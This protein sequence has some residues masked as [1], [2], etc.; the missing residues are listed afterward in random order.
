MALLIAS[1]TSAADTLAAAGRLLAEIHVFVEGV[2]HGCGYQLHFLLRQ[3]IPVPGFD[4][5][6]A[7]DEQRRAGDDYG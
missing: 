2:I 1:A 3:Q 4:V 6:A 5:G 7:A